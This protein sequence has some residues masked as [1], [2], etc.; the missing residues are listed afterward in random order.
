LAS[1]IEG[2]IN[3]F[4]RRLKGPQ[5]LEI[6]RTYILRKLRRTAVK[7]RDPNLE[8]I[9]EIWKPCSKI[10]I[11][12]SIKRKGSFGDLAFREVGNKTSQDQ[13]IS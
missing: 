1:E 10:K 7:A 13:I 11:E 3:F 6:W 4:T 8:T 9:V 2:L 5:N 12:N